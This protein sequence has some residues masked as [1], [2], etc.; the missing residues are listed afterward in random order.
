[1]TRHS[2]NCEEESSKSY[3]TAIGTAVARQCVFKEAPAV[4][5]NS[6]GPA[7]VEPL[8]RELG[9]SIIPS[10]LGTS[11]KADIVV[12]VDALIRVLRVCHWF[13]A[14]F[15]YRFTQTS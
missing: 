7:A 5:A 6:N 9:W 4:V 13:F 2:A 14:M 3:S 10:A 1:L 12:F 11:F 8:A 15:G